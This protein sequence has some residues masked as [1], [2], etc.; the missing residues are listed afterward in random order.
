MV[1]CLFCA[2]VQ[3]ARI[4]LNAF[5]ADPTVSVA[6]DGSSAT[7][8]EDPDPGIDLV[9]LANDPGLGDPEVIIPGPG[10]MLT[11]DWSFSEAAG[12]NDEFGFFVIDAATGVS[13]GAAYEMFVQDTMAGAYS[14]DLSALSGRTLGAQFQL[15]S[16]L[17][18]SGTGSIVIVSDLR[19][20]GAAVPAPPPWGLMLIPLAGW[21]GWKTGWPGARRRRDT[22]GGPREPRTAGVQR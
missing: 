10:V 8:L 5:Y 17:G 14:I 22:D 19:L 9:L 6:A 2:S 4:D 20:T 1:G 11:F 13:A 3:A 16:L 12:E 15:E 18:D 21:A 7:L